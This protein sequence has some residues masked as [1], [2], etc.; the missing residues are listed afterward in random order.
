MLT[1]LHTGKIASYTDTKY[2]GL[3]MS[4][5]ADCTLTKYYALAEKDATRQRT[6]KR[7]FGCLA[8]G[9]CYLHDNKIR[10]RDIKPDNILVRGPD[11]L[12]SD[13]G[14]SLDW[15]HLSR[16]TTTEDSGKTWM[17]CAPEVAYC[18]PRN[19]SS[20]VWSLGCV[21]LEMSTVL[22]SQSLETMRQHF[23]DRSDSYRF[24]QNSTAI[25]EWL[26]QLACESEDHSG[27]LDWVLSMLHEN[28]KSRPKADEL[29]ATIRSAAFKTSCGTMVYCGECCAPGEEGDS[30]AESESDDDLWAGDPA[31]EAEEDK[32]DRKKEKEKE[33]KTTSPSLK[34]NA[35]RL[36]GSG[37]STSS[38]EVFLTAVCSL[39]GTVVKKP[40]TKV[41]HEGAP[42]PLGSVPPTLP[43]NK[44]IDPVL[45]EH[46]PK[47]SFGEAEV[48]DGS[49]KSPESSEP[50]TDLT[51]IMMADALASL[52]VPSD[53]ENLDLRGHL[54]TLTSR[55]WNSPSSL[56]SAFKE[57]EDFMAYLQSQ[58][59][60]AHRFIEIAT[61]G[62]ITKLVQLLVD[63]GLNV[64]SSKD[65]KRRPPILRIMDWDK[66]EWEASLLAMIY[67]TAAADRL[68]SYR[69]PVLVR[70]AALGHVGAMKALIQADA[71]SDLETE[72]AAAA[73]VVAV[74][75]NQ[76]DA[77]RYLVEIVKVRP[78]LDG[79]STGLSE[80]GRLTPLSWA[81]SKGHMEMVQVL[82]A[83]GASLRPSNSLNPIS[84]AAAKNRLEIVQHFIE[85]GKVQRDKLY[86]NHHLQ[87]ALLV[88]SRNGHASVVQY[89]LE[90]G[91][92]KFGGSGA[93]L[94]EVPL[95]TASKRGRKEVVRVLLA[96]G[97][98]PNFLKRGASPLHVAVAHKDVA[99]VKLLLESG[100]NVSMRTTF[101]TWLGTWEVGLTA[102]DIARK[103]GDTEILTLL[104]A[105]KKRKKGEKAKMERIN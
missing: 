30:T 39:S 80:L 1:A 84:A 53:I 65:T 11:V 47:D 24:Y 57:D 32:E 49:I 89:L 4:P 5:V 36:A 104:E 82:F 103:R 93:I 78:D 74:I 95:H 68:R 69:R 87:D 67:A 76:V 16:S 22:R 98:N 38:D 3:I 29:L 18:Q 62:D 83:N 50:A 35:A 61:T 27:P 23:K 79:T 59:P 100:A 8:S 99:I 102:I 77:T 63:N 12:L 21:F 34:G 28:P 37:G 56:L 14:I 72:I 7:F 9:L 75:N 94:H 41:H 15:E 58:V 71:G 88:A 51:P 81:A 91:T 20:D 73:L 19:R 6:M 92:I 85:A 26:K 60:R 64:C 105:A 66:G 17:Y 40:S 10:H 44:A 54:P 97:A 42:N 31:E 55:S 13:F 45:T 48:S 33:V 101:E 96:H 86:R 52:G 90:S 25:Q 2:F 46:T 43:P 70:A